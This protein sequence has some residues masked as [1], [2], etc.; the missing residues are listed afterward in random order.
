MALLKM[1]PKNSVCAEVGVWK[2]GFSAQILQIVKPTKLYLIDP[3]QF[4]NE[5]DYK[6]SLYGG[7]AAKKQSDMDKIYLNVNKKFKKQIEAGQVII[8]RGTSDQIIKNLDPDSLDWIYIDG[9]H[10]YEAVKNDILLSTEK[11]KKNGF[12]TGDDYTAGG[13]WKGGVKNAVDELVRSA[14]FKKVEII[15]NQFILENS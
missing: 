11:V 6:H 1:M 3:W 14:S 15:G 4:K 13:W 9:D 12:I 8:L 2:G 5:G 10:T 7:S